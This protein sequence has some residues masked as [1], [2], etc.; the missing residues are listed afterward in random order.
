MEEALAARLEL[1][2]VVTSP[3]LEG[4]PRGRTLKAALAAAGT[5]MEELPDREFAGLAA[6][7]HPQGVLAVVVPRPWRLEDVRVGPRAPALVRPSGA[8]HR[9]VSSLGS[10]HVRSRRVSGAG[11]SPP[12]LRAAQ[13]TCIAVCEAIGRKSS[14]ARF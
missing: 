7:D 1:R 6:T 9:P 2:S 12:A 11:F 5:A 3:A 4:T 13:T 14:Q 8:R 10:G